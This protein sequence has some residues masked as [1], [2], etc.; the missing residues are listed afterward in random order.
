VTGLTLTKRTSNPD[1]P[2]T[3]PCQYGGSLQER[4]TKRTTKGRES[5]SRAPDFSSVSKKDS[6]AKKA[7][8][9]PKGE[10][11]PA[12]EAARKAF[13]VAIKRGVDPEVMIAG[14]KRYAVERNEQDPKYTKH[15]ATWLNAGC[16]EDEASGA[17]V[18]D[19][20][21]NVVAIQQPPP[22]QAPRGYESIAAEINAHH[23]PNK[24][25]F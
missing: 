10:I 3:Q 25:G 6:R 23:Q 14:A 17:P 1:K 22:Q 7:K 18:I 24:W 20:D 8:S 13:A 15:P 16:W 4:T 2:S 19:Q 9:E 5:D 21:G 11:E 12:E